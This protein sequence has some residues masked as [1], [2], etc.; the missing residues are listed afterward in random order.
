MKCS[1]LIIL[2][3]KRWYLDL[4]LLQLMEEFSSSMSY[5][6]RGSP[7]LAYVSRDDCLRSVRELIP[8][9]L[10]FARRPFISHICQL[11]LWHCCSVRLI[12]SLILEVH[13]CATPVT[14]HLLLLSGCCPLK[15]L[16]LCCSRGVG[17]RSFLGPTHFSFVTS[18][19]VFICW[20]E[21]VSP[22]ASR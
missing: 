16:Y 14:L 1:L 3:S 22:G 4:V 2:S 7:K 9:T 17:P 13:P 10:P 11:T 6:P 19:L 5:L 8:W 20:L 21:G 18:P 15:H 12:S